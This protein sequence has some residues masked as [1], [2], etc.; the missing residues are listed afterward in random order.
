[1]GGGHGSWHGWE[2]LCCRRRETFTLGV[3]RVRKPFSGPLRVVPVMKPFN[4]G[5]QLLN[6]LLPVWQV[7]RCSVLSCLYLILLGLAVQG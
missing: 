6:K 3:V 2:Q 5:A 1:M 7:A 4:G